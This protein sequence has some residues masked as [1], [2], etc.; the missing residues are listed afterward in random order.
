VWDPGQYL[1]FANERGRPFFD[2]LAQVPNEDI[3]TAADLG[4]GTGELTRTLADR[5]P[6]ARITG[7]DNSRDMLQKAGAS[8]IPGRL[9][10]VEG[11]IATWQS[12][13]PLDLIVSNAALHWVADHA[14]LLR[15]FRAML[16]SQGTIAVQMPT[17]FHTPAQRAIEETVGQPRWQDLQDVGLHADCVKPLPWY[18]ERLHELGFV[19]NAWETTYMH[20]L[21]GENHVL[22][23]LKGTGLRPVLSKL[24]PEEKE[25]FELE[26]GDRLRAAYPRAGD[27]TLFPFPR[28]FFVGRLTGSRISDAVRRSPL[29]RG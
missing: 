23:W 6:H 28:L 26:L 18:A 24:K 25:S 29:G 2:L 16:T 15:A 1:K 17:R 20:V 10:F 4:C 12:D 19:V 13:Q 27:R 14:R 3:G 7:V 5:W 22:E 21:S 9:T 8:I 11:D